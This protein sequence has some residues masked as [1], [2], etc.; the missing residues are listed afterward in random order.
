LN[1]IFEILTYFKLYR[2]IWLLAGNFTFLRAFILTPQHGGPALTVNFI[3]D[4]GTIFKFMCFRTLGSKPFLNK[5]SDKTSLR[6][7]LV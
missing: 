4:Y 7:M 3:T 6:I 1:G 5:G 2:S